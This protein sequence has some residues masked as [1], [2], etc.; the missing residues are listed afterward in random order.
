MMQREDQPFPLCQPI[1]INL[2]IEELESKYEKRYNYYV[3]DMNLLPATNLFI[4]RSRTI[5]I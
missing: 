1:S 2:E 5:T 4:I 3:I